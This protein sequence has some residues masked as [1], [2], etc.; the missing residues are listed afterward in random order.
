MELLYVLIVIA[1]IIYI[2]RYKMPEKILYTGFRD[3]SR[4]L[5]TQ[6]DPTRQPADALQEAT[7]VIY[8]ENAWHRKRGR[9][10]Y[11]ATYMHAT[12][13]VRGLFTFRTTGADSLLAICNGS[14]FKTTGDGAMGS[15]LTMP[16]G[17]AIAMAATDFDVYA[18]LYDSRLWIFTGDI[19][20]YPYIYNGTN[21]MDTARTATGTADS[22]STT[23]LV[24]NALTQAEDYWNGLP[25][26]LID[27]TDGTVWY[28]W[29]TNFTAADDT[30]TF[31]PA[32]PFTVAAGDTYTLG[33]AS[34]NELNG[35]YAIVF[36][37]RIF[38]AVGNAIYFTLPYYP[39][40]YLEGGTL[41]ILYPGKDDGELITGLV[42][43]DNYL[44]VF[45]PHNIY[46]F[47]IVGDK[48]SW[49]CIKVRGTNSDKGAV[50]HRTIDAGFG[51]LIYMSHDGVYVLDRS[52]NVNC[53]SR[54][55]DPTIQALVQSRSTDISTGGPTLVTKIDT[56]QADFDAGTKTNI[57][58]ATVSGT[59]RVAKTTEAVQQE[60][61]TGQDEQE[62]LTNQLNYGQSFKPSISCIATKIEIYIKKA[63]SPTQDVTVYLY[64]DNN[65]SPVGGNVLSSGVIAKADI[66]TSYAWETANITDVN[67]V[68]N[69]RY[70][71]CPMSLS[72]L[73]NYIAWGVDS[74]AA[75]YANGNYWNSITGNNTNYDFLFKVY[76]QH[77][78][79]TSNLISQI[80][81]LGAVPTQWSIF[82]ATETLNGCTIAWTVRSDDDSGMASPTAWTAV[83]NGGI[84]SIT[85]QRYVQ[86]KG[87]LTPT[88]T[89]TPVVNDVTIRAYTGSTTSVHAACGKVYKKAYWL[90]VIDTGDTVN[91]CIYW[92]DED[93]I[94]YEQKERWAKLDNIYAYYFTI[95]NDQL[96]SGSVGGTGLGGFLYYEDVGTADLG[97]DFTAT[98]ITKKDD[99][100]LANPE[101]S[102]RDKVFLKLYC[103]YKSNVTSSLYYK[104]DEDDWSSALSLSARAD[105]GTDVESFS[106]LQTG[107]FLTLKWSQA[108]ADG[109]LQFHGVDVSCIVKPRI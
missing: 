89:A 104:V 63:G 34:H 108:V 40:E 74:T 88:N 33:R 48:D 107:R 84:P 45:K 21:I 38:C 103:K 18:P 5:Y 59:F 93:A 29:V 17:T 22:G 72:D 71:I 42:A 46:A 99:F 61:I 78:Q 97:T 96:I 53:V 11:N 3:L 86:W 19:T 68:A 73:N 94:L 67:L 105:T 75:T 39:M 13:E 25:L 109:I 60:Y 30:V 15:A 90:S 65:N 70:W 2:R 92:L 91:S 83:E 55:I 100:Q 28:T 52:L 81:D 7:N 82:D 9:S 10:V 32:A 101:Y 56:S 16:D 6:T 1:L 106:G 36:K 64:S 35:K 66:G 51:G 85:L 69:T 50:W 26:K 54:N 76:E 79:A 98:L 43:L 77:Y 80:H 57:D 44:I 62:K 24:D 31:S 95:F 27:A 14:F 102:D 23:T 8:E 12:E 58:T 41:N 49:N 47:L 37:E 20:D 87:T 4:G